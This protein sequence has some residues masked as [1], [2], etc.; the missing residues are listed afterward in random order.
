MHVPVLDA[1]AELIIV[2]VSPCMHVQDVIDWQA[3]QGCYSE[4]DRRVFLSLLP[5]HARN[6]MPERGDN[7][8]Y[9]GDGHVVSVEAEVRKGLEIHDS[10]SFYFC[11]SPTFNRR[12][13]YFEVLF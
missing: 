7:V 13:Y 6:A 9:Y 3:A 5:A 1:V 11:P 8:L 10:S 4:L 2:S 12:V